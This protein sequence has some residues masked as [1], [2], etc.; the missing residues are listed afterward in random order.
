[1]SSA[2]QAVA[3]WISPLVAVAVVAGIGLAPGSV[4]TGTAPAVR[5][6]SDANPLVGRPF[7]VNP[8]SKGTRAAA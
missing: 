3:R 6:A 7:Y 8:N 2:A 4:D 5:L 1:M